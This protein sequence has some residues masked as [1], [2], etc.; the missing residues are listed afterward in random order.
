MKDV[1]NKSL[2]TST[3]IFAA[4][5]ANAAAFQ[6]Q[7]VTTSGL[8]RAYAGEA[9]IADNAGVVATNPALMTQFKRPEIS[10]GG[11]WVNPGVD[12]EGEFG[13]PVYG[14]VD[15]GYSDAISSKFVPNGYWLYPIN[16]QFTIG[17][18]ANVNYGLATDYD[19]NYNAGIMGGT[20]DLT[21]LNLNLSGAY[22][23]NEHWSFGLGVDAVYAK[24]KLSRRAGAI[25][26]IVNARL[27]APLLSNSSYL[28]NLEGDDWG[29]GWNAGLTYELDPNNRWGLAFHSKV[30][31]KFDG[32][33]SNDLP[34]AFG[35]LND[36][37]GSVE[38]NLPDFWEFSGYHKITNNWAV[39]Y[40]YKLTKWSRV[41]RLQA[42]QDTGKQVFDKTEHFGDTSR[43][44]LGTTY[45]VNDKLTLRAG[46]A[47]DEGAA[48]RK[49]SIS[50]PDT[51]RMWYSLGATYNFT[52]DLSV[53]VAYAHV[54]GKT[55][56]FTETETLLGN[57]VEG[58]Y[59]TRSQVNLYGLN[60]NYRF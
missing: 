2:I 48:G 31:I 25:S 51:N 34:A 30:K 5:A 45:D 18:G 6:L 17:G 36:A 10:F 49:S 38:L 55:R 1:F 37:D 29:F 44:A 58:H 7:E 52:P 41:Q 32:T 9:A 35:G 21:A 26:R 8:G 47:H 19:A 11:V 54:R 13:S 4:G 16:E 42:Y 53:D 22:R 33:L 60:V 43:F 23:L 40:S 15:A 57:T 39:H 28:T 14:Y 12:V 56:R 24:A 46:I 20:T 50:I 59:T 27:G 3:L